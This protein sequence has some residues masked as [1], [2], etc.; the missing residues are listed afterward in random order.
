MAAESAKASQRRDLEEHLR[1]AQAA[2]KAK[3][4]EAD[5]I[6]EKLNEVQGKLESSRSE[7]QKLEA[8]F[9]DLERECKSQGDKLASSEDRHR[10]QVSSSAE[11]A[12]AVH[13]YSPRPLFPAEFLH[14]VLLLL[15]LL[16]R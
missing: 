11:A 2:A 8:A 5:K 13:L 1:S 6:S 15:L 7:R 4:A 12:A 10:E 14:C 16:Q 9:K 3:T